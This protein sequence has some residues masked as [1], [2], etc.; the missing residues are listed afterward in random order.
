MF[1]SKTKHVKK[2]YDQNIFYKIL[3]NENR[4]NKKINKLFL[5]GK[6]NISFF[7]LNDF[8]KAGIIFKALNNF[9]MCKMLIYDQC[10]GILED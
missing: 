9:Y 10:K 3:K 5:S 1:E 6:T 2:E 8:K 4:K 7:Q